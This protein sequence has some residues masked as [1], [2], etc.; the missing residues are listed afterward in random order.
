MSDNQEKNSAEELKAKYDY[1]SLQIRADIEKQNKEKYEQFKERISQF[2]EI[3][4]IEDAKALSSKILPVSQE[5]NQ[6]K[7]GL[8]VCTIINRSDLFRISLNS[9]EEFISYDFV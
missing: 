5:K 1:N 3:E 2:A 9:E 8:G 4:T 7:V 6:F